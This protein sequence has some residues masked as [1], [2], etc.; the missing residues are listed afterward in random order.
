ME[1]K[2][3]RWIPPGG[4]VIW[5]SAAALPTTMLVAL[6]GYRSC[7]SR[8]LLSESRNQVE[9]AHEILDSL[10]WLF[11]SLQDAETG[12]LG[13][14]ISGAASYHDRCRGRGA[15]DRL[16]SRHRLGAAQARKSGKRAWGR[17]T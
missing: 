9:H 11:I 10:D 2:S 15:V 14:I 16:E 1:P 4:V 13:Y 7:R 17:S 8:H 12:E 6:G 3:K 5:T